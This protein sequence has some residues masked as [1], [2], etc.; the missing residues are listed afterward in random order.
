MILDLSKYV[1]GFGDGDLPLH[2]YEPY[3]LDEGE[4]C[5]QCRYI[6]GADGHGDR[7]EDIRAAIELMRLAFNGEQSLAT[8]CG[9]SRGPA[10]EK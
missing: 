2:D 4:M 7:Q 6:Y 5:A 1:R 3:S 10:K 8:D 9:D